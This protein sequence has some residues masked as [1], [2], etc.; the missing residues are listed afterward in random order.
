VQR[1]RLAEFEEKCERLEHALELAKMEGR[2]HEGYIANM[3]V[4]ESVVN[5]YVLQLKQKL[6][7]LEPEN[8]L[9]ECHIP[10]M[11]EKKDVQ[12]KE[13]GLFLLSDVIDG[14]L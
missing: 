9:L 3:K 13:S 14:R 6:A 2:V 12:E 7:E 10:A 11:P 1:L 4:Y 5:G 8:R